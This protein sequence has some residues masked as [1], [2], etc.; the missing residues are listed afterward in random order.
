MILRITSFDERTTYGSVDTETGVL[1]TDDAELR[2][3]WDKYERDGID[4]RVPPPTPAP[5]GSCSLHVMHFQLRD[6]V[7]CVLTE[8]RNRH[9][10]WL[11]EDE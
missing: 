7:G 4:V 2:A 5:A 9:G 10:Y 11:V 8:L 6:A 3:L 1:T